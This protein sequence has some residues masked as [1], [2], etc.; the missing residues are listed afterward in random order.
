M[1]NC[2]VGDIEV[3][4]MRFSHLCMYTFC[5]FRIWCYVKC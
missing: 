3:E 5:S 1:I 2:D 4:V